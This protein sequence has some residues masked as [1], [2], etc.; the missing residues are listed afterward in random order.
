MNRYSYEGFQTYNPE[1]IFAQQR[2]AQEIMQIIGSQHDDIYLDF[3]RVGINRYLT[4]ILISF[5]INFTIGQEEGLEPTQLYNRFRDQV[6]LIDILARRFNIQGRELDRILVRIFEIISDIMENALK[7]P[8]PGTDR[9]WSRWESLGGVLTT[10]PAAASWQPN[11]LDVF[12]GGTDN[13]LN[14]TWWDGRAWSGWESLGGELTSAPAAVSWEPNRIDAF[15][16][17]T[18]NALWHIWWDGQRWS[19]WESLGGVLTSSPGVSSWQPNRFDVFARGTDNGL[20]HKWWDG[21]TWSGWES[22]GGVLTSGP[23]VSSKGPNSLDVFVKGTNDILYKRSWNGSRWR[24]WENLGG[25]INSEPAA[26]SWGPDR[27][28]VFARGPGRDLIHMYEG[29]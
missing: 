28:D 8:R 19:N 2:S 6:P 24:D 14:H 1:Y 17:G 15:A 9:G 20:W 25:N 10:A 21:R 23:A 16:R 4:D 18:D 29:R 26:I 5:I 3:E 27:T 11:R 12:A 7:P 22:L 13:S